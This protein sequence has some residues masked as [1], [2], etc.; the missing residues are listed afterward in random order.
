V[1]EHGNRLKDG[2]N[3]FVVKTGD[4]DELYFGL[5]T[6]LEN[7][8]LKKVMGKASRTIFEEFNDFDKM[9]GGFR[10]A[11]AYVTRDNRSVLSIKKSHDE[12]QTLRRSC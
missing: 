4:V 9:F 10:R 1:S 8:Q 6:I 7:K 3:G 5:K 11:I 12:L 2:I